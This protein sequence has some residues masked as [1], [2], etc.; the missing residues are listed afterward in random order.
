MT[1]FV[2]NG[3]NLLRSWTIYSAS[4]GSGQDFPVYCDFHLDVLRLGSLGKKAGVW[5]NAYE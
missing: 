3:R 4:Q 1:I 5:L 2:N